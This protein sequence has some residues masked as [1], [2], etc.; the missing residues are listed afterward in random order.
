[1]SLSS[2]KGAGKHAL[3]LVET[4]AQAQS[5][6]ATPTSFGAQFKYLWRSKR[7]VLAALGCSTTP[8]L[9]GYDLTLIGSIIAN[10]EFVKDFGVF[11]NSLGQWTLPA[12]RQLIWTIVQ[13]VAAIL[14][15]LG[16][17]QLNDIFGR[18][19]CFF[20]TIGLTTAGALV[21]LFS[22]DWKVWLVAKLLMGAAMGSMQANTQTFVSEV[23]PVQIRGF[24]LSL[25]QFWIILGSLIA[26]CVLQGTSL[27][28]S[29]WSWKAAVITQFVPA[30]LSLMLFIPFVPESPYYLVSKGRVDDARRALARIRDPI[31]H[32]VDAELLE[33]QNT[34]EHERQQNSNTDSSSYL[35]CFQK[36]D[37]R[38]TMLACLPMFMQ[39]MLGFP[40]CGNYL[41][42]FLTLSGVTDAFLITVISITFS[43]LA[44][45]FAFVLIER[46]GRRPQL[47][48]GSYGM[49]VCLLVISL[50][51]FFGRG[52]VWNS[53]AL[54]AF[55]I[56]WA[57]FYYSSVGAVGWTIV[58]EISSS[59]LRAKTTSLAAISNSFVNM[60]WSIA[61]PYLVNTEEANLGAKSALIFLGI[62]LVLTV[63]AFF[64]VPETKG[65][66][67]HELD[68]LFI[69]HTPAREF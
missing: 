10:K 9:I 43:M 59:R 26:A 55:C 15:A 63:V 47:L 57:I 53:R 34:L 61:I 44:A 39:I 21:E 66:T 16:S 33:I 45:I 27:I 20:I 25:F 37:L 49:L 14:S 29:S 30:V 3:E 11:D 65:K 67:F 2:E 58:G 52:Q 32:D 42:Y 35:E 6:A 40:I 68:D 31:H 18:R 41:A 24:T 46:V 13:F 48:V 54:A 22:P 50:L 17:G 12:N 38:R 51:G 36:T 7:T 62:G 56:I 69:A 64:T 19:V 60:A 4:G 5:A 28:G 23:T 8:V 1:M